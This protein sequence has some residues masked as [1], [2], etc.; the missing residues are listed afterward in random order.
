[1]PSDSPEMA[2]APM[3]EA[4]APMPEGPMISPEAITALDEMFKPYDLGGTDVLEALQAM[5]L[6]VIEAEVAPPEG[7]PS[8]SFS[9]FE[10]AAID[11][12]FPPE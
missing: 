5:G 2:D 3:P 1:M 11:K 7:A 8:G 12:A 10:S 4:D 9:D 6:Q